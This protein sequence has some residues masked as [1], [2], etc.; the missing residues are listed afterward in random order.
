MEVICPLD[1]SILFPLILL[2]SLRPWSRDLHAFRPPCS[3]DTIP[4]AILLPLS[5][6]FVPP[7]VFLFL[8]VRISLYAYPISWLTG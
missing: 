8:L 2:F 3:G 4:V 5:L 7:I 1:G 6:L